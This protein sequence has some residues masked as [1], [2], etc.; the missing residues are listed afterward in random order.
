MIAGIGYSLFGETI[1]IGG[2]AN[3]ISPISG[4]LLL[5]DTRVLNSPYYTLTNPVPL[6]FLF[7]NEQLVDG[8]L[9]AYYALNAP[10]TKRN[11]YQ[12]TATVEFGLNNTYSVSLDSGTAVIYSQDNTTNL[13]ITAFTCETR[14][15]TCPS[16]VQC[17]PYDAE[18]ISQCDSLT[19][20]PPCP[21]HYCCILWPSGQLP[22]P[23]NDGIDSYYRVTSKLNPSIPSLNEKPKLT[24]LESDSLDNYNDAIIKVADIVG[25]TVYPTYNINCSIDFFSDPYHYSSTIQST[26]RLSYVVSSLTQHYDFNIVLIP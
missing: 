15:L 12:S 6:G 26:I 25:G 3:T 16:G 5:I 4:D 9:S 7:N 23:K 11:Q 8:S 1:N 20:A 2:S 13:N 18:H 14:A 21:E 17:V 19:M 24:T 22:P 10:T